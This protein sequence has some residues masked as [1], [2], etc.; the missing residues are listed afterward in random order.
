MP[1]TKII[2]CSWYLD[3]KR[4]PK[5]E[6]ER[7]R[8]PGALFYDMNS[9]TLP[10]AQSSLPHMA[11]S[12]STF[13]SACDFFN[14]SSNDDLVLYGG[15]ECFAVPRTWYLF[16]HFGHRGKVKILEGGL[17]AFVKAGGELDTSSSTSNRDVQILSDDEILE[18]VEEPVDYKYTN[19]FKGMSGLLNEDNAFSFVDKTMVQTAA[20]N[21]GSTLII[22]A[23][24]PPRFKGEVPEPRAGVRSGHIPGS[25]NLLFG[26]LCEPNCDYQVL[27]G[28][29]SLRARLAAAGYGT[30]GEQPVKDAIASCGS[31]VTACY[32]AL[33]IDEIGGDMNK[34]K[35]Y[36]GSWSEYGLEG[37]SGGGDIEVGPAPDTSVRK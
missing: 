1:K 10:K 30:D 37:D 22:D 20:G 12:P 7:C 11:P 2:D 34:V 28:V 19:Y 29:D 6:H 23:R 14:I 15:V 24:P 35:V 33:A 17:P 21:K 5:L 8:I 31:G 36:D 18:L 3:P 16:K 25:R 4:D 32:I 26:E 27:K 13:F 9:I